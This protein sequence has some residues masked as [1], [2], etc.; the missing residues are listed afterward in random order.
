MQDARHKIQ[1]TRDKKQGARFKVQGSAANGVVLI[2]RKV[3]SI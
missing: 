3:K 1:G 2:P